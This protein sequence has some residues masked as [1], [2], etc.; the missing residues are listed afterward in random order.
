MVTLKGVGDARAGPRRQPR[1][2]PGGR[3]PVD[4]APPRLRPTPATRP[5]AR[6]CLAAALLLAHPRGRSTAWREPQRSGSTTPADRGRASRSRASS[7]SPSPSSTRRV[8]ASAADPLVLD[9][10]LSIGLRAR[11]KQRADGSPANRRLR[12]PGAASCSS[13][14]AP[15]SPAQAPNCCREATGRGVESGE[16]NLQAAMEL[17]LASPHHRRPRIVLLSDDRRSR[18]GEPTALA[19]TATL[20]RGSP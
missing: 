6:S 5:L 12:R 15:N 13:A 10:S 2:R 4:L 1:R 3:R 17:A 7:S 14:A 9:R 19:A 18:F 20:N 16:S 11:A 8:G